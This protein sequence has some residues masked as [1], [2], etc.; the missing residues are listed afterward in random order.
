MD[1]SD[2][3]LLIGASLSGL[4]R[5]LQ[6]ALAVALVVVLT[7]SLSLA[8]YGVWASL[9]IIGSLAMVTSGI[10]VRLCNEMAAVG[11]AGGDAAQCR[12]FLAVFSISAIFCWAAGGLLLL[13][14][15]WIPWRAVLGHA[16]PALFNLARHGF[17]A[18]LLIQ[19][20]GMPFVLGSFGM[21]AFQK[22]VA[23]ALL[24]PLATAASLAI[25]A[26]FLGSAWRLPLLLAPF[27]AWTLIY[28]VSFVRFLKS[29][30]WRWRFVPW[31][32]AWPIFRPLLADCVSF[33]LL[34]FALAF[35]LQSIT[36]LTSRRL[37]Y[38]VAGGLDVYVK[39]YAVALAGMGEMLLPLWPAYAA[40]RA[41]NDW[42]GIRRRLRASLA[43]AAGLSL[44]AAA[45]G[46]FLAPRLV[47]LVTGRSHRPA[48]GGPAAAGIMAA[49][50]HPDPGA[51]NVP[52]RLQ[53]HPRAAVGGH[54]PAAHPAGAEQPPRFS[55]GTGR[56]PGRRGSLPGAATAGH[57]LAGRQR[58]RQALFRRLTDRIGADIIKNT[59]A[60]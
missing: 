12:L 15:P 32:E 57:G 38:G 3:S 46:A 39:I 7:R 47:R 8:E 5:L 27:A 17:L 54:A 59:L 50:R 41:A 23:A 4:L 49:V 30:G 6:V 43:G 24:G 18:A 14:S 33:S 19:V 51:A 16:D 35:L 34:A 56:R 13:L 10:G 28:F 44:A 40:R 45:G 21:R 53:C 60:G 52:Q 58:T 48:G 31:P 55:L 26:L 37:G 36:F 9:G 20:F 22:N 29:R 11:P 1:V 25:V 2:R 42:P